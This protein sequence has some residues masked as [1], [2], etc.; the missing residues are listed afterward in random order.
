[1]VDW[2]NVRVQMDYPHEPPLHRASRIGDH[3]QIKELV[4]RGADIN[5]VFDVRPIPGASARP[6]TPLM[7]AAGSGDGASPDTLRLLIELGAD[8]TLDLGVGTAAQFAAGG[9]PEANQPPG[10]DAE[11]LRFLLELGADP[12]G[13]D[14]REVTLLA[15]AASTGDTRRVR[16]LLDAGASPD[17]IGHMS[18]YFQIPLLCAAAEGDAEMVR[19]LLRAGANPSVTDDQ[20][21]TALFY[22]RDV[23]TVRT[24][25]EA[26][27]ELTHQDVYGWTPLTD[28]VVEGELERAKALLAVGADVN[29]THD[30]GFTVFMCAVSSMERSPEMMQLLLDAGADPHAI[31]E[32]GWNAFHAAIDVNGADANSEASV[33]STMGFLAKLGVDINHRD[34]HGITPLARAR[35]SGTEI[36]VRVLLE[37]GAK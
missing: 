31:S 28:S 24:L 6:A 18:Y 30:R 26:G 16:V 4:A 27:L 33:R 13:F 8:P 14:T 15:E 19:A 21:R 11:R 5:A 9:L 32:L 17:P 29:A 36:V 3:E 35:F 12:N 25:L 1:M 20:Q 22:A 7:V 37:L 2:S 34:H 10:G 23:D